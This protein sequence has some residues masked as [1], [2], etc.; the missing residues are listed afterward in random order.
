[1]IVIPCRECKQEKDENDFNFLKKELNKRKTI[2]RACES[3]K[4][5]EI[6]EKRKQDYLDKAKKWTAENRAQYLENQREYNKLR[7]VKE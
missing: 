2:C 7:R 3:I 5:K 4:N 1:M 6:Y